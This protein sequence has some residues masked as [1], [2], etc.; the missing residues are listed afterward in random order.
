MD[1]SIIIPTKNAGDSFDK[2]LEAIYSQKT[3]YN[4]EVICVDSGSSDNTIS[5]IQSYPCKLIKISPSEF[6]HGKTRNLGASYG[7]GRYIVFITQ[8]AL[9]ADNNW[10]QEFVDIM[11]SDEQIA[12]AFGKHI[13]YPDCNEVDKIDLK[14]HFENFGSDNRVFYLDDYKRYNEDLGYQQFL[15]FF[16]DNN[17]CIRRSVWEKF[18]YDDVN[19]S[20]DQL[21]AKRIIEMGYKK[22]YCAK[23]IVYHSHNYEL[24]SYF[25]RYYDEFRGLNRVFGWNYFNTLKDVKT[26]IKVVNKGHKESL[27]KSLSGKEK[28][29]WIKYAKKRNLYKAV[30]G[31]IAANYMSLPSILQKFFDIKI[32]Q[33]HY[34]IT[35]KNKGLKINFL[36]IKQF[37]KW[38]VLKNDT[39]ND[40]IDVNDNNKIDIYSKYRFANTN[41]Q[42][43]RFSLSDYK[44]NKDK[45]Y[46]N[47]IIPAAG[48]GSGGHINIFRFVDGLEK[49]GFHNRLYFFNE[50]RFSTSEECKDF[51]NKNFAM[52]CDS[53]EVYINGNDI[54]FAHATVAT[55]WESAYLVKRFNNT[56]SKFYFVQDFEPFFYPVGVDYILAENTYKFGFRGITAGYWLEKL[57]KEKYKMATK[58]FRFSYSKELYCIGNKRDKRRRLFFYARAFTTRRAFEF[59]IL[60]LSEIYKKYP[61]IEIILAGDDVSN[62]RI[63]FPYI[64]PGIVKEEDLSDLYAQCNMCMIL[65]LTNAS[66]LP[67]EVMASGSTVISNYGDNVEWLVNDSNSIMID[68]DV[69]SAVETIS[70]YLENT[71]EL[72]N[73][74]KAGIEYATKTS[75]EEAIDTVKN[76]ILNGIREDE[77]KL[78]IK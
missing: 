3:S 32:S 46:I 19:F 34:Q 20:E 40:D 67:I 43:S 48:I 4:Y 9:P 29:Y 61:E 24:N 21:W 13:P 72:D 26:W 70:Y 71:E 66:L 77:N 39:L 56:V 50:Y 57:L 59:G 69:N 42:S 51:I 58:G 12:G 53:M 1:V 27:E 14:Y 8:D 10:L 52:N 38:I 74:R 55:S 75:W 28:K 54:K 5:I 33:Q 35:G 15:C 47:W 64:N 36:D 17:S 68:F 18:P 45:L 63:D 60:V 76:T 73:K 44:K 25:A 6:G 30:A 23:A 2:V 41:Y 31:Y 22:A 78:E 11:D 62:Y 65:S 7:S 49:S 16:S 37:F